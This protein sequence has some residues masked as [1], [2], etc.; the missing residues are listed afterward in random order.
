MT[1]LWDPRSEELYSTSCR[2]RG[3][4]KY[5]RDFFDL[6]GPWFR[7]RRVFYKDLRKVLRQPLLSHNDTS[8]GGSSI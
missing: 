7:N 4:P 5:V 8:Q 1:L 6:F 2:N 3:D